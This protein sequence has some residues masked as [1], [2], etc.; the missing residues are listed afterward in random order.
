M[1]RSD[2]PDKWHTLFAGH[3]LG[4]LTPDEQVMLRQLLQEHP[5]LQSELQA[6]EVVF[7]Q[8]P[9]VSAMA[10]LPHK[11]EFKILQRGSPSQFITDARIFFRDR[12]PSHWPKHPRNRWNNS[13]R[14]GT[15][16]RLEQLLAETIATSQKAKTCQC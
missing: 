7:A 12:S 2:L 16:T 14:S 3:A 1:T 8:I 9:Q 10:L 15:F 11:L 6:Y 13:Y 4:D 5:E